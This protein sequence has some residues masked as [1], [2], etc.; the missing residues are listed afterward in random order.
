MSIVYKKK[1]LYPIPVFFFLMLFDISERKTTPFLGCSTRQIKWHFVIVFFTKY[2]HFD[3][4]SECSAIYI[5]VPRLFG[6][7][8][9]LFPSYVFLWCYPKSASKVSA[10]WKYFLRLRNTFKGRLKNNIK[11]PIKYEVEEKW[12]MVQD[13][14]YINCCIF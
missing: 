10:G 4:Q 9:L 7:N 3:R 13:E 12:E 14:K 8:K 6:Y 2:I 1:G 11:G 5:I